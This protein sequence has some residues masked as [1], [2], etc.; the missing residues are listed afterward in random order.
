MPLKHN[1]LCF[2]GNFA[3]I[4]AIVQKLF[5]AGQKGMIQLRAGDLFDLGEG[6]LDT[7]GVLRCD[8]FPER[9]ISAH[10][11]PHFL[12]SRR[13]TRLCLCGLVKRYL[14]LLRRYEDDVTADPAI[15]YSDTIIRRFH[16]FG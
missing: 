2:H 4:S 8:V 15:L 5:L 7:I 13:Q 11:F 9:D 14:V 12:F 1:G 10:C 16:G 6:E 3:D